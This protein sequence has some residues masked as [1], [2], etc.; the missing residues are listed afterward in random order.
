MKRI[1]REFRATGPLYPPDLTE[2]GLRYK[3]GGSLEGDRVIAVSFGTSASSRLDKVEKI[4]RK[5]G[6]IY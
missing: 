3:V 5:R 1:S 2:I 6:F 4:F